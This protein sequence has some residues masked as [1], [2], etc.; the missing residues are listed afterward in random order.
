VNPINDAARGIFLTLLGIGVLSAV[1]VA[2]FGSI[3]GTS[4]STLVESLVEDVEWARPSHSTL[5]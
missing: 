3:A 1:V 2:V 4:E 5:D